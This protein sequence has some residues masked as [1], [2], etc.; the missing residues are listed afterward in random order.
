MAIE[1]FGWSSMKVSAG[2]FMTDNQARY[3]VYT[4]ENADSETYAVCERRFKSF[5]PILKN[6][7]LER[8]PRDFAI[9]VSEEKQKLQKVSRG[10]MGDRYNKRL[11]N[12]CMFNNTFSDTKVALPVP[13]K[14]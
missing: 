1:G 5:D 11:S 12:M 3:F 8:L 7:I 4:L 2:N 10:E 13:F 9:A 14:Q 6:K